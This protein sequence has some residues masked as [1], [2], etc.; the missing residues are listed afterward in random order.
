MLGVF[1]P[2]QIWASHKINYSYLQQKYGEKLKSIPFYLRQKYINDT[3]K[4]WPSATFEER[5]QFLDTYFQRKAKEEKADYKQK[6]AKS[7][8]QR[9]KDKLKYKNE[10][11]ELKKE[12]DKQKAKAKEQ[13][14]QVKRA[15]AF[16]KMVN[17]QRKKIEKMRRQF[18]KN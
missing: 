13:K 12:R 17:N 10:Q 8:V 5:G 15:K 9:T 16:Q 11:N 4:S 7:K 6:L 2:S 3:G 18:D 14:G 1:T